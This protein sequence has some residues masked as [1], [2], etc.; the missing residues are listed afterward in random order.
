M[1][2]GADTELP[3]IGIGLINDWVDSAGWRTGGS[4]SRIFRLRRI[5]RRNGKVARHYRPVE[6]FLLPFEFVVEL[7]LVG[8]ARN[9][10]RFD[11]LGGHAAM[12]RRTATGTISNN[13][14]G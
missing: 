1:L 2:E 10:A 6:D 11:W 12:P 7:K 3:L 5:E 13:W 14:R 8:D 9:V 4:R